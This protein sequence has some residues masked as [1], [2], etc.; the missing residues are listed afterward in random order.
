[1]NNM[2]KD[3]RNELLKRRELEVVIESYDNPGLEKAKQMVVSQ[4]KLSAENV[5]VKS[6]RNNFGTHEFV[7]EVFVYDSVDDMNRIEPR[8]KAN[9]VAGQQGAK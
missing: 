5:V 7:V 8:K 9:K 3:R 1:M 6:L 2:D 4:A